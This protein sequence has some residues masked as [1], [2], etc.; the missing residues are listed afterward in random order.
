MR[1]KYAPAN[2]VEA[3]RSALRRNDLSTAKR[4]IQSFRGE[5]GT[6][7]EALEAL[8]WFPRGLCLSIDPVQQRVQVDDR[9]IASP[10]LEYVLLKCLAQLQ[11]IS[12]PTINLCGRCEE[13]SITRTPSTWLHVSV[14]NLRRKIEHDSLRPEIIVTEP[15]IGY[16]MNRDRESIPIHGSG[17][18]IVF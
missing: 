17:S 3:A 4:L 5:N 2:I 11:V 13:N 7:P 10:A 9:P 6:T 15:G 18:R 12:S 16:R 14:S 1:L 8:S